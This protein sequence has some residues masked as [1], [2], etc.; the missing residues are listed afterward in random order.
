[1]LWFS[2]PTRLNVV[3]L[4]EGLIR[5]MYNEVGNLALVLTLSTFLEDAHPENLFLQINENCLDQVTG[6]KI[7]I[8][9]GN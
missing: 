5:V 6:E 9:T 8:W 7:H 4:D 3:N 2:A 1:M